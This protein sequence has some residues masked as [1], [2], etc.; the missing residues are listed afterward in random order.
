MDDGEFATGF[1]AMFMLYA[2]DLVLQV[3]ENFARHWAADKMN[4]STNAAK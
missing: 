3:L 2:V 4:Q 1:S